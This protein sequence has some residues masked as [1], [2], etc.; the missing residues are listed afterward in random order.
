M[1]RIPKEKKMARAC[2]LCHKEISN[3]ANLIVHIRKVHTDNPRYN[4]LLCKISYVKKESLK[5]HE[6]RIHS[7][8]LKCDICE[9]PFGT[10]KAVRSHV[11]TI[12]GD[13]KKSR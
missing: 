3:I 10:F 11:T 6:K 1:L 5:R 13:L 9:R 7:K 8:E 2:G 12:H 4:C